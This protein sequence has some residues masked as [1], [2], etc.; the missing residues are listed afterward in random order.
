M[1]CSIRLPP[2]YLST[3]TISRPA[4]LWLPQRISCNP[5]SQGPARSRT[6][7]VAD[8]PTRI[9]QLFSQLPPPRPS[10]PFPTTG[11]P[12]SPELIPAAL[13][14]LLRM[15]VPEIP[16]RPS[17]DCPNVPSNLKMNL[18]LFAT[19]YRT[20]RLPVRLSRLIRPIHVAD[21]S[22]TQSLKSRCS[23][24]R[25]WPRLHGN[26]ISPTSFKGL[27]P[28]PPRSSMSPRRP[29]RPVKSMRT[30]APLRRRSV[31]YLIFGSP[32]LDRGSL[33]FPEI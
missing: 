8:D 29:R 9:M 11:P 33:S 24:H 22:F 27:R 23:N 32:V 14:P 4:L 28:T 3:H 26:Y 16:M 19:S 15:R 10:L 17:E 20:N 31:P 7:S 13:N 12:D 1:T 6:R 21:P 18:A 5:P 2:H 30:S 25:S